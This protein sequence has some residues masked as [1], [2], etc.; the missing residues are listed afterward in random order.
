[1]SLAQDRRPLYTPLVKRFFSTSTT[2]SISAS[3]VSLP[4][5]QRIA[6]WASAGSVPMATSTCEAF[7]VLPWQ[8][9]PG[10]T[11]MPV[12]ASMTAHRIEPFKADVPGVRKLFFRMAIQMHLQSCV[13]Q[14]VKQ[15]L[16]ELYL[17]GPLGIHDLRSDH[18]RR[19]KTDDKCRVRFAIT[20][21]TLAPRPL[22]IARR[23]PFLIYKAPIPFGA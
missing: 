11:A 6:L 16:P 12:K 21:V 15:S 2:A 7:T 19:A 23:R 9:A 13:F 22:I 8:A 1:M 5:P 17:A 4:R 10:E 20:K 18:A 3:V 14:P